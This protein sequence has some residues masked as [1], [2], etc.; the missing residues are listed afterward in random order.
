MGTANKGLILS[1]GKHSF[2]CWADAD[3]AGNW[4]QTFAMED[5]TMARSCSRYMI[6]Y[7]GCLLIWASCLQTEIALSTMEAENI[8]LSTAL[9]KVIALM[10]LCKELQDKISPDIHPTPTIYCKAFEDNSGANL[11]LHPRC[12]L[13]QNTSMQNTIIFRS[14]IDRKLI[15][16][17]QVITDKQLADFYTK[18]CS[19]ELFESFCEVIL[20]WNTLTDSQ[21]LDE[22]V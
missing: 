11:L 6:T 17:S 13:T 12:A 2:E 8:S 3:Y 5:I 15:Q 7:V 22:G 14:H 9:C 19:L 10:A 16:I 1:P 20:G 21:P 18:Q 4:N